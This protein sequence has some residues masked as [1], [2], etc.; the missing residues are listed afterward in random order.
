VVIVSRDA[1]KFSVMRNPV[2]EDASVEGSS[3]TGIPVEVK[4]SALVTAR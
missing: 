2:R 3:N 4:H 1:S